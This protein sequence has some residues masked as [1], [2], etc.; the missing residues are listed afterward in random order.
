MSQALM[1]GLELPPALGRGKPK[2]EELEP[3][4][5]L[6]EELMGR[7]VRT[8]SELRKLLGVGYRTAQNWMAEVRKRWSTGLSDDLI[9]WRRE[10]LYSEADAIARAAWVESRLADTPSEKA[11]LFK[12]VLMAN[13]RKASLTGLDGIEIKIK[14]EVT[15]TTMVDLVAR[16]ETQHGLAPGAL[17]AIGRNAAKALSGATLDIGEGGGHMLE[18][19]SGGGGV[20]LEENDPQKT[21]VFSDPLDP[22]EETTHEATISLEVDP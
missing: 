7:G 19:S 15:T 14:K 5:G 1:V 6:V 18:L 12:V 11:S 3:W 10:T 4:L 22:I 17:E 20:L 21:D 16:V 2:A 8:P 9:N 13:Q